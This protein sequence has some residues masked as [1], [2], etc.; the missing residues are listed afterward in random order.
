M[1]TWFLC[2]QHMNR[3]WLMT[4][5][6]WHRLPDLALST[7]AGAEVYW[8]HTVQY[9]GILVRKVLQEMIHETFR[10][11]GIYGQEWC[12]VRFIVCILGSKEFEN[13][14]MVTSMCYCPVQ[15]SASNSFYL[16]NLLQCRPFAEWKWI[17]CSLTYS[18]GSNRADSKDSKLPKRSLSK[19]PVI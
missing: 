8:S 3:H 16:I 19:V 2:L 17:G 15:S 1:N 13:W 11:K 4:C 10:D 12:T 18:S 7:L 5:W 14:P 9:L 6:K